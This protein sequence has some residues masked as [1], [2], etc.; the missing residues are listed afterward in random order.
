MV[1]REREKTCRF[2]KE[3]RLFGA[4]EGRERESRA[5]PSGRLESS[6]ATAHAKH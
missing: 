4:S 2:G 5:V 3:W 1:E 6:E